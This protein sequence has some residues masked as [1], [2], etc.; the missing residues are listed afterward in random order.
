MKKVYYEKK[1]RRYVPV[2]EYD[3]TL[4]DSLP[5]GSHLITVTPN[6]ISRRYHVNPEYAAMIAAGIVAAEKISKLLVEASAMRP[7]RSTITPEQEEAWKKL[8]EAFGQERY[9]LEWPSAREITERGVDAMQYEAE[10]LL[11][12]PTVKKAWD[13]F[14][15]VATLTNDKK[16][17]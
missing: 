15:L 6:T 12:N 14:M 1:G 3:S 16:D 9:L 5:A 11:K 17:K 4:L 2:A 13:H 7:S 8:A 10:Q